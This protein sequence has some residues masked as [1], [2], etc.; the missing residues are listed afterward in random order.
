MFWSNKNNYSVEYVEPYKL[1]KTFI[2]DAYIGTF[3]NP[4]IGPNWDSDSCYS[5]SLLKL[6]PR[7]KPKRNCSKDFSLGER[8]HGSLGVR[9]LMQG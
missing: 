7:N 6:T 9:V 2:D 3:S 1:K 8:S 4:L 5:L